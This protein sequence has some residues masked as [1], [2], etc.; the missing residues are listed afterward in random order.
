MTRIAFPKLLQAARRKLAANASNGAGLAGALAEE[1]NIGV[2]E[3]FL[4]FGQDQ[5]IPTEMET[6]LSELRPA[7]QPL[8]LAS[9]RRFQ[10]VGTLNPA[11]ELTVLLDDPWSVDALRYISTECG[12][13]PPLVWASRET[14]SRLLEAVDS[15]QAPS[16]TA[17]LERKLAGKLTPTGT[18]TT[19]ARVIDSASWQGAANEVVR[20]VDRQVLEAWRA[21]ASDIHIEMQRRGLTV[22]YRIDGVLVDATIQAP[23]EL[24]AEAVINRVKVLAQLDISETRIP[25]DGRFRAVVG[26]RGV[27]FRVSIMP[28]IFGEDAVIRLLDKAQ[29]RSGDDRID[30]S[31]LGFDP[32]SLA[33]LGKAGREPHGM[34]L[35]TGPTGSGKTTTLY[36]LLSHLHRKD[37]KVITIEDP[38]EYELPGVLQIPVNEKKGLTFARGLRSILRHDPD[39]ILVGEIRDPETA[40]IAVQAALTGHLVF[41]TVHANNVYDVVGRFLHMNVDLYGFVS[42]LNCIVAQRLLRINCP[43]CKVPFEDEEARQALIADG[44][45][46]QQ[47]RLLRGAG[48]EHCRHTGYEGRS[49]V[50]EV[51]SVDDRF[52]ELVVGRASGRA[53]R[54]HVSTLN[55]TPLR[56]AAFAWLASGVTTFEEISRV[57]GSHG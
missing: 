30:L 17:T 18:D 36:A 3:A 15:T 48:C 54:E 50:A 9:C 35:I 22:K 16:P 49:A 28:S 46:A 56:R 57:V 11:G 45:A 2:S 12:C 51:L 44:I 10:C 53:L 47:I 52:R 27:D 7:T 19:E 41:T 8:S 21:N 34:I 13:R 31:R 24:S 43:H 14:V 55:V 37:E 42:S 20:F 40:E 6:N 25:Q 23:A 1:A 29:L 26:G 33:L 32:Q 5:G 4:R 39:K 38:V